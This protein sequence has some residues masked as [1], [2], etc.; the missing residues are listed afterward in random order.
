[1]QGLEPQLGPSGCEIGADHI[2]RTGSPEWSLGS[3]N[4]LLSRPGAEYLAETCAM[5]AAL[6]RRVYNVK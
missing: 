6:Q 2:R 1:V 4:P 5:N 3:L